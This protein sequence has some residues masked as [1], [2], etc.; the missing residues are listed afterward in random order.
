MNRHTLEYQTNRADEDVRGM[1]SRPAYL[2]RNKEIARRLNTYFEGKMFKWIVDFGSY[3]G[4]LL[5]EFRF[6]C[7]K[8]AIDT[9]K[10]F[11]E[12]VR[13]RY[14][15]IRAITGTLPEIPAEIGGSRYDCITAFQCLYYL[16]K[17][18][19]VKTLAGF[20]EL[21]EQ[22]GYFLTDSPIGHGAPFR[23]IDRI[24]IRLNRVDTDP[25]YRVYEK[26]VVLERCLER[27]EDRVRVLAKNRRLYRWIMALSWRTRPL[28]R[29]AI[30]MLKLSLGV[31][32]RSLTVHRLLGWLGTRSDWV[33]VYQEPGSAATG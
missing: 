6:A 27:E 32:Y 14:P 4:V 18:E 19:L 1:D 15:H 3:K 5:D 7:G 33:D 11:V 22:G 29:I 25:I 23:L 2:L 16:E 12:H 9:N 8:I 10:R 24:E 31:T 20:H 26:I 28:S 30:R 17:A 13:V 21:M